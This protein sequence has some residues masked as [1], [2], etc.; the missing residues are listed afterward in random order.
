MT[1][2][3]HSLFIILIIFLIIIRIFISNG[4]FP[5]V[6]DASV[7][8]QSASAVQQSDGQEVVQSFFKIS[9]ISFLK[10]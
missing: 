6:S 7:G 4:S 3:T 10:T 2:T 5:P 9:V 1:F 8:T